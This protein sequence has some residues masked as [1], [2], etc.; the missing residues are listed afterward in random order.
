MDLNAKLAV[1]EFSDRA[2]LPNWLHG[3]QLAAGQGLKNRKCDF[4]KALIE[5]PAS[6]QRVAH[7]RR[8]LSAQGAG[9]RARRRGKQVQPILE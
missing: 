8:V 3:S 5:G 2:G 9:Q 4:E 7:L 1:L 6:A